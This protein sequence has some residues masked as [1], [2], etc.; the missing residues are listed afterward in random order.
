MV[1]GESVT[2]AID[3]HGQKLSFQVGDISVSVVYISLFARST[4][5][6]TTPLSTVFTLSGVSRALCRI[7]LLP[8]TRFGGRMD[9]NC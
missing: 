5:I 6:L 7:K 4:L 1:V 3:P 8:V 9:V 2:A